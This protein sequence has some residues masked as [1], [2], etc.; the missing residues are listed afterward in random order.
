MKL[1]LICFF[2][3]FN[4]I[5]YAKVPSYIKVCG[6]RNPEL[7]TC[8][9][10]SVESLRQVL[11]TGIP[12]LQVPS[13]DYLELDE[14][15]PLADTKELKAHAKDVK[16]HN[17]TLFQINQLHINLES[18]SIELDLFLKHLKLN[19]DYDVTA[20]IIVPVSGKGPIEIDVENVNVKTTLRYRLINTKKGKQLFFTSMTCKLSIETYHS[21]FIAREGPDATFSEAINSVLNSSQQE[22]IDGIIPSLEKSVSNKVLE[23]A[24]KICK[25][26][27]YDELFPDHE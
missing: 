7:D 13:L 24:N 21:N 1:L 2:C 4:T 26:F 11:R 23:L 19:G 14:G 8:I 3:L 16:L 10:N 6:R 15:L 22:I 27:T 12:E 20:R 25:H 5:S 9:K 18:K 17:L